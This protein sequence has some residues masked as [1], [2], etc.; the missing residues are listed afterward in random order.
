MNRR[1]TDKNGVVNFPVDDPSWHN[2]REGGMFVKLVVCDDREFDEQYGI[3]CG[4][5]VYD[6]LSETLIGDDVRPRPETIRIDDNDPDFLS[7]SDHFDRLQAEWEEYHFP[8]M[9]DAKKPK[10]Y[11]R[12][13]LCS[14]I[15]GSTGWSGFRDDG[16]QWICFYD[17]LTEEGKL[18][19]NQV[20][21]LYPGC[22]LH[23]LTFLDT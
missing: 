15:L 22:T 8:H 23:L 1:S 3:C 13:Y 2:S 6:F 5:H 12:T 9:N 20:I 14:M 17:D 16:K 7:K 21:Q 11:S 19:Y 4:V 10:Y 18:L